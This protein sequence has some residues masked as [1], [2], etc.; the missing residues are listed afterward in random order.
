MLGCDVDPVPTHANLNV[1]EKIQPI[2]FHPHHGIE[3]Q[4]VRERPIDKGEHKSH[5]GRKMTL[6][7]ALVHQESKLHQVPVPGKIETTPLQGSM[8]V[9]RNAN[10]TQPPIQE[11]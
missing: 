8:R 10:D 1:D 2:I 7:Q 4:H 9:V 11:P 6:S 3:Q 5:S